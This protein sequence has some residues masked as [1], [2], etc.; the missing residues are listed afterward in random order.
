[1][2]II[3]L[4]VFFQK[5]KILNRVQTQHVERWIRCF[6][7]LISFYLPP[8]KNKASNYPFHHVIDNTR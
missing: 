4:Y 2:T 7:H 5:I 6:Q 1:M 3:H 8:E